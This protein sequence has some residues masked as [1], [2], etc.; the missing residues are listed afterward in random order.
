M[1]VNKYLKT[2]I[3]LVDALAATFGQN[4]EVVLHDLSNPKK[5]VVKIANGQITGRKLGSP[6]TDLG[7]RLLEKGR[8]RTNSDALIGYRTRTPRGVELKSTT[9]LIRDSVGKV[10]GCLC[11][12]L[13][14]TPYLTA[15]DFLEEMCRTS[16][17]E[18]KGYE[19]GY[20]EKFESNVDILI[21]DLISQALKKVG[22]PPAYMDK[23]DKLQVIRDLKEK[24]IFSIRGST[25]KVSKE[26][27]V[28]LPTIYKYLEE[29]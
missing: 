21:N 4:C 3:P 28:A 10:V 16:P 20:P 7:L 22:K 23:G 26:L 17:V 15:K 12:N 14:V 29:V 24:G 6:I 19:S 18:E 5:S 25:K 2:F 9:V 8:N 1:T 27:N 13:D 11:I